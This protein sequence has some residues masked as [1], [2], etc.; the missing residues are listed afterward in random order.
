[1]NR[2]I[3]IPLIALASCAA[4]KPIPLK[5]SYPATP[6]EIKTSQ[7]FD[8][9]WDKLIDLFSQR[10]ISIKIIDRSSGL[11][12]SERTALKT[13]I[14]DDKGVLDESTAWIV[15][16]KQKN[17]ATGRY[18]PLSGS[19]SG[20]YAK[21]MIPNDVI[22]DWNVRIKKTETGCTI[23]VNITN[24]RYEEYAPGSNYKREITMQ[25][26]KSTGVFEKMISDYI[27]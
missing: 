25:F 23:N 4:T 15:V 21:K 18:E 19:S 5:G 17:Q 7:T 11:I 24:V 26:H 6:I 9:T 12:V 20:V 1:M 3:L 2:L 14:E 13:T 16:P 10:G 27:K 22:G 8:Q